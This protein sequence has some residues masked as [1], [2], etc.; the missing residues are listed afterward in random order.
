MK[1]LLIVFLFYSFHLSAQKVIPLSERAEISVITCGPSQ[2][3]LYTAFG[4]SAFRVFD[5]VNRIDLAYNYGVFN[6]NQ[7]NFYLNFARGYL[8]YRLGVENFRDFVYPYMYFN[9]SVREQVLN[10]TAEQ[11]QKLFEYLQVNARPENQEYRYDYFYNNCATKIRDVVVESLGQDNVHFDGSYIKTDYS[12]RQLTD[13]YLKQQ[14][15]GDLGI[16]ICLGLPMDKT[17]TPYEYMFLPDYIESGFEHATVLSDDK[18]QIPIVKRRNIIYEEREMEAEKGVPH[19]LYFFVAFA[20]LVLVLSLLD[21]RKRK[22]SIWLDIVLFGACGAIGFLLCFLWFFTDHKAAWGNLNLLW[23]FPFHLIAVFFFI[24]NPLWLRNYF[25]FSLA[26]NTLLLATWFFLPQL[27]HYALI[28]LV[29]ALALRS[30][31]QMK[32]RSPRRLVAAAAQ[33]D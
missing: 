2:R 25:T 23:A 21:L 19:P 29:A 9:R 17:A 11:K 31:V 5:P 12:I 33:M 30:Y 28:P 22:I 16:D 3:E 26:L 1:K 14:P 7:P 10:L 8:Y 20:L 6:F 15:W 13:L 24:K 32:M 4:H 18:N 27:M